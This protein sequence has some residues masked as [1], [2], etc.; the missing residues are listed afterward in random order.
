MEIPSG[1][2]LTPLTGVSGTYT[3]LAGIA[4]D[5]NDNVYLTNTSTY[6]VVEVIAGSGSLSLLAGN[7]TSGTTDGAGLGTAEFL[8]PIAIGVDSSGN[9]YVGDQG[10]GVRKIIP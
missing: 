1:G 5:A 3:S 4:V 2:S 10:N 8:D 6:Q 9:V 7:G